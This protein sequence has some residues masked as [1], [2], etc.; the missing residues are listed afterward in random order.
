[1]FFIIHIVGNIY[2]SENKIT[3]RSNENAAIPSISSLPTDLTPI[4]IDFL[5]T[6]STL[7]MT[8]TCSFFYKLFTIQQHVHH[9]YN[10]FEFINKNKQFPNRIQL[11]NAYIIIPHELA[12]PQDFLDVKKLEL[13]NNLFPFIGTQ[14]DVNLYCKEVFHKDTVTKKPALQSGFNL[15]L[16][17]TIQSLKNN[18]KL[19]TFSYT[20]DKNMSEQVQFLLTK[21]IIDIIASSLSTITTF[22]LKNVKIETKEGAILINFLK[23]HQTL[24]CL[25]LIHCDIHCASIKELFK[26]LEC[27]TKL[28]KLNLCD[29]YYKENGL[30]CGLLTDEDTD[31][32]DSLALSLGSNSTITSLNL[33][34]TNDSDDEYAPVR[35]LKTLGTHNSLIDLSFACFKITTNNAEPYKKV[36]QS[37]SIRTLDLHG[38]FDFADTLIECL[39]ILGSNTALTKLNL[40]NGDIHFVSAESIQ[41]YLIINNTTLQVLELYKMNIVD[42]TEEQKISD[43]LTLNTT[44][45]VLLTF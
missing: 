23:N 12:A 28:K 29:S 2:G 37:N 15:L 20:R 40:S 31:L 4:I 7:A 36:M 21:P 45:T 16:A 17:K 22:G 8:A 27:N 42:S 26:S 25:K 5:D 19:K 14:E 1:M 18:S 34:G 10:A 39:P 32:A 30:R 24:A 6:N 35:L 9:N 33:G 44:K 43:L 41:R 38:C 3:F 11:K 13:S